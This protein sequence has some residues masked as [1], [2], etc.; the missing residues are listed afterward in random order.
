M[1]TP[2]IGGRAGGP[3]EGSTSGSPTSRST[4]RSHPI[5]SRSG[6]APA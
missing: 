1:S 3:A 2:P 5:P 6:C 4:R